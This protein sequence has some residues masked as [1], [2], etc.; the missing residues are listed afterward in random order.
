MLDLINAIREYSIDPENADKNYTLGRIYEDIGQ[1][2]AAISYLLRAAERTEDDDLAYECLIRVGTCFDRQDNRHHTV[3]GVYKHAIMHKPDRPE[4]YYF[5]SKFDNYY[6]NHQDGY[7][8]ARTG[9]AVANPNP[10]PL[11]GDVGYPGIYGLMLEKAVAGWLWGKREECAA[12][13]DDI[14][15]NHWT[16]LTP[17]YK[18]AVNNCYNN[19]KLTR[20]KNG[21]R[22]VDCFTYYDETCREMLELRYNVLKNYVDKFVVCEANRTQTGELIERKLLATLQE[23]NLPLD[24][25][26]IVDVDIPDDDTLIVHEIDKL[27]SY[28]NANIESYKARARE[29]LQKNGLHKVVD[30]FSNNTYF[31]VSDCDE[32]VN[33]NNLEHIIDIVEKN[34]DMV[35]KIPLIHL[36]GRANLRVLRTDSWTPKP[37]DGAM[38][39]CKKEHLLHAEVIQIRS[40]IFNPYQIGYIN[41]KGKRVEDL[42]WHFSW[43]GDAYR[44]KKKLNGFVHRNEK[45]D[46]LQTG[47]YDSQA[48]LER[49]EIE[50]VAGAISI[51]CEANTILAPFPESQLPSAI[52]ENPKLYAFFITGSKADKDLILKMLE[53]EYEKACSADTDIFKHLPV[54][55][56]FAKEC[57]HIT[58]MG[59]R[60]GQ[61]TRALLVEPV[62]LRSYDL[63]LN[64]EV[65]KLFALAQAA[66]KDVKY[67]EG[68]TLQIEI[69]ET[70][71]LFIDTEHTYTQLAA[72]LELH[73]HKARK[74]IAF[75]DTDKPFA[76]ELLPAIIEFMI[77]H[78]EWEF[79]HHSKECHGFTVIKRR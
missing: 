74:Y 53:S 23:L 6:Q 27:N 36:E 75:H 59:V 10:T 39:I 68:D 66:D 62:T 38:F 9:L 56:K 61:S 44:R 49:M 41:D 37:W 60:T 71:L 67:I 76:E 30:Q 16:N 47:S 18:D 65:G 7:Y 57:S 70:D 1:T 26:V 34:K 19:Y 40:N 3:R 73:H 31:I 43:M 33:P 29:R 12:L 4:A 24:K 35:V 25:F 63:Y 79:C 72:E 21:L 46:F 48:T 54:L 42:G 8:Y 22:I 2:A 78:P 20:P 64:D 13:L 58:E 15:T 69:D 45:L 14:V 17:W 52:L 5:L 77:R 28:Q 32:I 11:R 55:R 51:S 50:P